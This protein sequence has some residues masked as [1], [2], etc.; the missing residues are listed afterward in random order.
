MRKNGFRL[1]TLRLF[2][3]FILLVSLTPLFSIQGYAQSDRTKQDYP[4]W[5]QWQTVGHSTL[6]WGFWDIYDAQLK[7]LLVF[8][9]LLN[10][11]SPMWLC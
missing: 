5:A 9:T 7:T 3:I 11:L 6:K 4:V 1:H 8:M 2:D 10:P